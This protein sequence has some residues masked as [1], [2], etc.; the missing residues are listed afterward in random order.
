MFLALKRY[1]E[2]LNALAPLKALNVGGRLDAD[3]HGLEVLF[4]TGYGPASVG[5]R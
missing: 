4:P 2:A 3:I 5:N 1:P